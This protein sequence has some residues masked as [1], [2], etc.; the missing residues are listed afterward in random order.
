MRK[1]STR[2][3]G[4]YCVWVS[5]RNGKGDRLVAI[6][7]DQST[8]RVQIVRLRDLRWNGYSFCRTKEEDVDMSAGQRLASILPRRS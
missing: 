2:G 6:W 4:L 3:S 7:I 5:V 1:I 8:N